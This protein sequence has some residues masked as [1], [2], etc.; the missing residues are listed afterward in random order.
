[1]SFDYL[2]LLSNMKREVPEPPK[3][4]RSFFIRGRL[5]SIVLPPAIQTQTR[6]SVYPCNGFDVDSAAL[7]SGLLLILGALLY[8]F[9]STQVYPLP[10]A[11]QLTN[12]MMFTPEDWIPDELDANGFIWGQLQRTDSNL[13]LT[14]WIDMETDDTDTHTFHFQSKSYGGLLT[15]LVGQMMSIASALDLKCI[16]PM[17][18]QWVDTLH[19]YLSDIDVTAFVMQF[20]RFHVA[21][22]EGKL[23]DAFNSLSALN[24]SANRLNS[25]VFDWCS[26]TAAALY[27]ILCVRSGIEVD[28]V[29]QFI[30]ENTHADRGLSVF[31]L[32]AFRWQISSVLKLAIEALETNVETHPDTADIWIVL[33]L[34]YQRLSRPDLSI[35]VCQSAFR[36]GIRD[37]N[38]YFVYADSLID[39]HNASLRIETLYFVSTGGLQS[40]R[41][42]SLREGLSAS[43]PIG[44]PSQL[45]RMAEWI[46][47]QVQHRGVNADVYRVFQQLVELDIEGTDIETVLNA[48]HEFEDIS[49]MRDSLKHASVNTPQRYIVWY[50]LAR[51]ARL[52]GDIAQ[53]ES[54]I[55]KAKSL[56][57]TTH[58]K[59]ASQLFA[60]ELISPNFQVELAEI[61]QKLQDSENAVIYEKDLEFLEYIVEMA[62][63]Y[64]EA[65]LVLARAYQQTGEVSTALEVLLDAEVSGVVL[66]ELY[67][68]LAELLTEEEQYDLALEY[69]QKGLDLTPNDVPLLTQAALL[70]HLT[71][72]GEVAR[73]FLKRAHTISAFHPR[74]VAITQRIQWDAG[75]EE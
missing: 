67:L 71:G 12:P 68:A 46:I 11:S 27:A 59:A 8:R 36:H 23:E 51:L 66:P 55:A 44:L 64:A 31:S 49:W 18:G 75:Q 42:H 3:L 20:Y 1:M 35:E 39:A 69:V 33:A 37:A 54:A 47:T 56:A 26:A 74:I 73:A 17:Q 28:T 14:V 41:L 48:A 2:S 61:I 30:T 72:D 57:V 65:Q 45:D 21:L 10:F 9:H 22:A 29:Q 62:P 7:G 60:L 40:E 4:K 63:D 25:P 50:G 70:S 6:I 34:T 43:A 38:L 53:A 15:N 16:L 58:Q 19:G 24:T 13:E 5:P 32:T 52:E